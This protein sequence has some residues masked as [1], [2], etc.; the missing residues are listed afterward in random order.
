MNCAFVFVR[1][2]NLC[3]LNGK[4]LILSAHTE[5]HADIERNEEATKEQKKNKRKCA[6]MGRDKIIIIKNKKCQQQTQINKCL[7]FSI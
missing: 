7:T 3:K 6:A 4:Q 2:W 5:I 1:T